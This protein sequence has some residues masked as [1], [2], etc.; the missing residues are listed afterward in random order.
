MAKLSWNFLF[1]VPLIRRFWPSDEAVES[2][3]ERTYALE[4][5]KLVLRFAPQLGHA[6]RR[7]RQQIH[8][9]PQKHH[10]LVE[11][12]R[13]NEEP[14]AMRVEDNTQESVPLRHRHISLGGEDQCAISK[15]L[16]QG[17]KP[18]LCCIQGRLTDRASPSQASTQEVKQHEDAMEKVIH[19]GTRVNLQLF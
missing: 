5:A 9:F 10:E 12:F 17:I 16:I 13:C 15:H 18:W 11:L 19:E 6:T 7:S 4:A 1:Q 14:P 3:K 8:N 2:G